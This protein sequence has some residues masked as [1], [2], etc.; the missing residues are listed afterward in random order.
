MRHNDTNANTSMV[1]IV[2]DRIVLMARRT[3]TDMNG[4]DTRHTELLGLTAI[5][6]IGWTS[7][8]ELIAQCVYGAAVDYGIAAIDVGVLEAN[9]YARTFST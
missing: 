2:D 5:C 1:T 7:G 4:T 9:V 3:W 8:A 6:L